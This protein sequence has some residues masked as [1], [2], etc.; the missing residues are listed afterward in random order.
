MNIEVKSINKDEI[1]ADEVRNSGMRQE[2]KGNE[3]K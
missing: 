3:R 2:M 1:A